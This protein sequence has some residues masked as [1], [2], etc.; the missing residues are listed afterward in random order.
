MTNPLPSERLKSD[1]NEILY[2]VEAE[3]IAD[4]VDHLISQGWIH[5]SRAL[6]MVQPCPEMCLRL[7]SI[8][9]NCSTCKGTGIVL[10]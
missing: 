1:I 6:E 3:F 8:I 5:K 2:H 4:T 7:G 9:L 10:K